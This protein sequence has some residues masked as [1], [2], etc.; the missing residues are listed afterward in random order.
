MDARCAECDAVA[1]YDVDN[2]NVKCPSC[3]FVA[4]YDEYID[5][6]A[7]KVTDMIPD[8]IPDRPGM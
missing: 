6:M 2:N 4:T 1:E 7:Q 3:G 5:M 8:Y